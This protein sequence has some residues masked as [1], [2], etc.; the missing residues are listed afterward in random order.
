MTSASCVPNTVLYRHPRS[1]L[2]A[3]L[4]LLLMF[5]VMYPTR[6][7]CDAQHAALAYF[8]NVAA[9]HSDVEVKASPSP[10]AP[11]KCVL[12]PLTAPH[13]SPDTFYSQLKRLYIEPL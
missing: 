9:A 6:C 12:L 11:R 7:D 13:T 2:S 4:K 8:S 10:S 1:L 5:L 3:V